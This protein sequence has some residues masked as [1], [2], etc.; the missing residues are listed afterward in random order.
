MDS[1][2]RVKAALD[3]NK[4]DKIPYGEYAVDSPIIEKVLGRDCYLRNK[5]KIQI[6]LWEN[7]RD[8]VAQ[9][10]KE[11]IV[12][13]YKKIDVIDII[14]LAADATCL[15]PPK[16]SENKSPKRIDENTWI[17]SKNRVYKYSSLTRDI[18]IV[19]YPDTKKTLEDYER[20]VKFKKP[21]ESIF[22]VLDYVIKRFENKKFLIGPSGPEV[23]IINLKGD[24]ERGLGGGNIGEALMEYYIN[25]LIIKRVA[26]LQVSSANKLDKYYIRNG[27]DGIHW[28][29]DFSD[30]SGPMISPQMFKEFVLLYSK[31]RK[32]NIKENFNLPVIKHACG[33]NWKLMDMFI[34]IGYDC[35]QSIQGSAGMDFRKLKEDYGCK[36][37]LWGGIDSN[38]LSSEKKSDKKFI[39][40]CVKRALEIGAQ[41]NGFILGTSHSIAVGSDYSSYMTMLEVINDLRGQY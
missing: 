36:I 37:C 34:E 38:I 19:K 35:Y 30:N 4:P 9:G 3:F 13:F 8:E 23:A 12:E 39:K 7:R 1:K 11:D 25:P 26:E 6:A 10:L 16:N 29:Q 22:E 5:A 21:D 32:K 17:D 40:E 15:L 18:T 2:Q 28:G 20:E 14:N 41:G 33:N 24:I 31:E 27:I